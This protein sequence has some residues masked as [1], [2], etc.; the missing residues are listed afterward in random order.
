MKSTV[1]KNITFTKTCLR[2]AQFSDTDNQSCA[3]STTSYAYQ[4]KLAG[5]AVEEQG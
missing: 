3:S 2:Q 5:G 4:G 1:A